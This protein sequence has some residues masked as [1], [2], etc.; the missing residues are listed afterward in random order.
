M[1]VAVIGAGAMG[2]T[3]AAEM[4]AVGGHEVT[5]VD[6]DEGLVEQIRAK[7]ATV[8]EGDGELTARL[9]ATTHPVQVGPVDVVVVFVKAQH[10]KSAAIAIQPLLGER[11]VV[12]TLQ[13]GWGNADVLANHIA[14]ARL[15]VGVTY[16]S[17]TSIGEGRMTH[18][19]RGP[20][21]VGPYLAGASLDSACTVAGV[22]DDAG[23]SSQVSADV[24]TEIWKKLVLNA[25]TLP[26]AALSRLTAGELGRPGPMLALVD[27]LADEAVSVAQAIG[28]DIDAA[29]RR[30]RI[31][32]VLAGA[33]PAKA[34]MLQDIEA[35][36]RTEIGTVNGAV[37]QMGDKHG[38][39][40]PL[41]RAMVALVTG[42]ES[43]LADSAAAGGDHR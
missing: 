31:H 16:H 2:G 19:G 40:V 3:V 15:V 39:E 7:G 18:V 34:S 33:G 24:R 4:A 42:L 21:F 8:T 43:S 27:A 30:E 10:T 20:T 23:W 28:L 41:N 12:A 37:V 22:L 25:A 13:N 9:Q 35:G 36:R 14:P 32:V 1:K 17:C 6:V 11:T 26:T 29:E 38:V 5:V